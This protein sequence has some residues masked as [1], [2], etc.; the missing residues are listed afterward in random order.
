M[1]RR[2]K[3]HNKVKKGKSDLLGKYKILKSKVKRK[4]HIGATSILLYPITLTTVPMNCTTLI[5]K[6]GYL[7]QIEE[8]NI[9]IFHL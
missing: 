1:N 3:L 8:K 9:L 4:S 2:D 6:F 7:L 5:K